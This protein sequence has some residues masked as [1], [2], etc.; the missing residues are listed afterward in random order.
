MSSIG[1]SPA[2]SI[3]P[4]TPSVSQSTSSDAAMWSS[5][6]SHHAPNKLVK[7]SSS[8]RF[9]SAHHSSAPV[10]RRPATS[11]QRT[12]T[13]QQF[14]SQPSRSISEQ[15]PTPA[16]QLKSDHVF[17]PYFNN[18]D[19]G[20]RGI[21]SRK[22]HTSGALEISNLRT[23]SDAPGHYPTLV[24]GT[25]IEHRADSEL[26]D[27]HE[28]KKDVSP[29]PPVRSRLRYSLS[30]A[31]RGVR[32][33][34]MTEPIKQGS[35]LNGAPF[36]GGTSPISPLSHMSPFEIQLPKGT[37]SYPASPFPESDR[38]VSAPSDRVKY[39]KRVSTA[40]SDPNSMTLSSD[41]DTRVFTDDESYDFQSDTAYDSLATRAT[42]SSHSG[43]KRPQIETIFDES[44]PIEIPKDPVRLQDLIAPGSLDT[45]M[46]QEPNRFSSISGQNVGIGITGWDDDDH[47]MTDAPAQNHATPVKSGGIDEDDDLSTPM[48][49]VRHMRVVD[50]ESSPPMMS[51][52]VS[53]QDDDMDDIRNSIEAMSVDNDELDWDK[54]TDSSSTFDEAFAMPDLPKHSASF[55]SPNLVSMSLQTTNGQLLN[56]S[57]EKRLSAFDY[58]EQQKFDANVFN[59]SSPRPKTVHG[60]QALEGRGSRAPGRRGPSAHFRSQSVPVNRDSGIEA[61][62]AN[63]VIAKFGTWGLGNKPVSEEWN[64]DFDFDDEFE[65]ALDEQSN[66]LSEPKSTLRGTIK[67]PQAIINRQDSVHGQF[68]QVQE[69]M[70]LV[71]ELKR[72]RTQGTRLHLLD[73]DP[74]VWEDA[75]SIVNLATLNDDDDDD[76]IPPHSPSLSGFDDFDEDLPQSSRISSSRTRLDD[77]RRKD[78]ASRLSLSNPA[79]P[80]SGRPRG[81][82]LAQAKNFL[83]NIHEKRNGPKSS[84]AHV[85]EPKPEK[86]PFDT[87]DLRK[88]VEQAGV[89][90][91]GLKEIIRK[92]E[93][94]SLSP[95]KTPQRFQD[96]DFSKIFIR[97]DESP[98]P[99][100]KKPFLPKSRSAN[101]YLGSPVH[102]DGDDEISGHLKI[103]T[104]A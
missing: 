74:Q 19:A 2:S 98:S 55:R 71:E 14:T 15:P 58:S 73:F 77:T 68:N 50:M 6:E 60:K 13:L 42:V 96:P 57:V 93:G 64:D 94:L 12:A 90:S 44:P 84:P 45:D 82:S 99:T 43:L 35:F 75:E 69:F 102:N 38:I 8:Q 9:P 41:N 49:V 104:V 65:N 87:Q 70:L 81:E 30:S 97:P 83:Q 28:Q 62:V 101:S 52:P 33:R 26:D 3:R 7:R 22:R 100:L 103:M 61:D 34:N 48:T 59:G 80:P 16:P 95:E 67:V 39:S 23:I 31:R 27:S 20:I 40:P 29:P 56:G 47:H 53:S 89:I 88:L 4:T 72:L 63:P 37:P 86:L 92:A 21:R 18:G 79:T 36:I 66:G 1:G 24:L 91:K 10:L 11:H 17:M 76:I 78:S 5:E 54:A 25:A 51:L 85:E 46:D 32:R